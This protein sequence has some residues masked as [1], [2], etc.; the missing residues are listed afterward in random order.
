[1]RPISASS[2]E[3]LGVLAGGTLALAVVGA[4]GR[5]EDPPLEVYDSPVNRPGVEGA[6]GDEVGLTV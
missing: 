1:M 4:Q 6:H 3:H 2:G 5:P